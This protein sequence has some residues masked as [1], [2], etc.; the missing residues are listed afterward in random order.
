VKPASAE[1][2]TIAEPA[3]SAH[4]N[5]GWSAPEAVD[6][7]ARPARLAEE[8]RSGAALRGWGYFEGDYGR[9]RVRVRRGRLDVVPPKS[10]W[11][12]A[13]RAFYLFREVRGDF[14]VRVRLRV[15]GRDGAVPRSDWSLSGLLV[16]G[17]P[18]ADG[19][20][21][22]WVS[23]RA[24]MVGGRWVLERKSTER[25]RSR[26]SLV[27]ARGGWTQLRVVRR[28]SRFTLLSRADG[29]S[30]WRRRGGYVRADLPGTV[31]VGVDAFSGHDSPGADL[32]SQVDWVRFAKP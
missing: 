19:D 12:D 31:Q 17:E 23:L 18:A 29:E 15:T 13:H 1:T 30:A 5:A 24:G 25:S 26:L 3:P 11:V 22:N 7:A 32:R 9:N 14:D 28:G 2:T 27:D 16:R 8:F 4:P 10:A 20:P 6:G 21:E